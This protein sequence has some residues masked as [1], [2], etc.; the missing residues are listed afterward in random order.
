MD[1]VQQASEA[2]NALWSG[3]WIWQKDLY[4]WQR[5]WSKEIDQNQAQLELYSSEWQR[6]IT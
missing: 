2:R 6:K 1:V 4:Q 3:V 5:H